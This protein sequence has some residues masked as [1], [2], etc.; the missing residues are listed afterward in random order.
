MPHFWIDTTFNKIKV[1]KKILIILLSAVTVLFTTSNVCKGQTIYTYAGNGIGGFS[2]DSGSAPSAQIFA[3]RAVAVDATGNVYIADYMNDRIRKIDNTGIITTIAGTGISGF[4]GDGGQATLAQINKPVAITIDPSGNIYFMDFFNDRI[5]KINTSGIISTVVGTGIQGYSGD[6]GPANLAQI[7]KPMGLATDALGNLY[8]ADYDNHRI[9]K[10]N[11]AGTITTICGNGI[12]GF[13]GDGN[14]A[15]SAQI[16]WPRGIAVDAIGNVYFDGNYR[17]RKINTSGIVTTVAGNGTSGF[18][19][20]GGD[21]TSAQIEPNGLATDLNNN[22]YIADEWNNHRIRK[23]NS[24]GIIS[25]IAG[26][27]V[28][29]FSGDG[30]AATSAQLNQPF[31]VAVDLSSNV[32]IADLNNNRIRIIC[33]NAC[34]TNLNSYNDNASLIKLFPNPNNGSFKLQLDTE[35]ENGEIILLNVIG[36]KVYSQKITQ[37]QNNI[38]LNTL[39]TGIYCYIIL[40]D[41]KQISNGKLTID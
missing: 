26:T 23:V 28:G 22:L 20:D 19:G 31:G 10:V 2:G 30:G 34:I 38:I 11:A 41:T 27:G 13:S 29:G 12:S 15:T 16:T 9:R 6:G 5:R 36:E 7:K 35:I 24:S 14:L 25:T 8:I 3:P 40:Q 37:G 32:Y 1:M 33:Y 17:V 18:S 21:A 4:S 39:A